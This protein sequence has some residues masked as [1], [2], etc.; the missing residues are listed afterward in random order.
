VAIIREIRQPLKWAMVKRKAL[1]TWSIGNVTL[2]G[3]ACHAI[4]PFLGQG[5][6]MAIE[7]GAVLALLCGGRRKLRGGFRAVSKSPRQP[8]FPDRREVDGHLAAFPEPPADGRASG[9]SLRANFQ[10][11]KFSDEGAVG[12][13]HPRDDAADQLNSQV[14]KLQLHPAQE[15]GPWIPSGKAG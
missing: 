2:L 6:A 15:R 3:D 4:L 1:S 8:N 7:D 13:P 10:P 9:E 14:L 5:A 12:L 11:I